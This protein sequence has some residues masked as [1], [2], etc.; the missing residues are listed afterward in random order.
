[1]R[2]YQQMPSYIM[3]ASLI[4]TTIPTCQ[5]WIHMHLTMLTFVMPLLHHISMAAHQMPL[6][7]CHLASILCYYTYSS[8]SAATS[9]SSISNSDMSVSS[10]LPLSQA[11]LLSWRLPNLASS[12]YSHHSSYH[13]RPLMPMNWPQQRQQHR[14]SYILH[15]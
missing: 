6:P 5:L 1:M 2:Q 3:T 15:L 10:Q 9:T 8:H 12:I 7:L 14:R 13:R 4:L 11:F